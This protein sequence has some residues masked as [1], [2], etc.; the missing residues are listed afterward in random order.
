MV[1]VADPY[2]HYESVLFQSLCDEIDRRASDTS[3]E[4]RRHFLLIM[5]GLLD[6]T[7][8]MPSARQALSV[9]SPIVRVVFSELHTHWDPLSAASFR[10]R[11]LDH[12]RQSLLLSEHA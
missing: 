4:N 2:D 7:A 12:M 8:P 1:R 11:A 6:D 9:S 3:P 5:R 10:R